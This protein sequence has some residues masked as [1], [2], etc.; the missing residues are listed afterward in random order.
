VRAA[1]CRPT[2]RLLAGG[3]VA[4]RWPCGAEVVS[5]EEPAVDVEVLADRFSS[6][7]HRH[8]HHHRPM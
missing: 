8:G 4:V 6:H 2:F 3:G 5:P 1:D 7:H